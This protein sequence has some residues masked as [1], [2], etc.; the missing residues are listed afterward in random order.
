MSSGETLEVDAVP[1][2][3]DVLLAQYGGF[4]GLL[5][6]GLLAGRRL[7]GLHVFALLPDLATSGR[8]SSL[9]GVSLHDLLRIGE[10]SGSI[11]LSDPLHLGI[12]R[13]AVLPF[14]HAHDAAELQ[15]GWLVP[16]VGDHAKL[17]PV[18]V[19]EGHL[20]NDSH[21][22]LWVYGL[23]RRVDVPLD[24]EVDEHLWDLLQLDRQEFALQS[25]FE[26]MV[27]LVHPVKIKLIND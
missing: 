20:G 23:L 1:G 15:Y 24:Q 2:E 3:P 21:S 4:G 17:L 12:E 22:E 8:S 13:Y 14:L 6:G 27:R 11:G 26:R 7:E 5:F 19:D 10:F 9:L 18:V 25:I 16:D